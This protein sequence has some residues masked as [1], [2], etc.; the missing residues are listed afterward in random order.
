MAGDATLVSS[1]GTPRPPK[2]AR[3]AFN[4]FPATTRR[5]KRRPASGGSAATNVTTRVGCGTV[6]N[7]TD[8]KTIATCALLLIIAAAIASLCF[9]RSTGRA[10]INLNPYE[11]LGAVAAEE[12]SKLLGDHREIVM[13]LNDPGGERDPVLEAQLG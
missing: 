1:M 7:C 12:T 10:R 8:R 3:W 6:N 2:S 5:V 13:V 9:N 4:S 11:A